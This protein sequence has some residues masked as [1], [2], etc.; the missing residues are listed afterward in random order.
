MYDE[1]DLLRLD[2]MIECSFCSSKK[3]ERISH[4]TTIMSTGDF[5]APDG[6]HEHDLNIISMTYL[7]DNEHKF[8]IQPLNS[9]WCGWKQS[10]NSRGIE[11]Y[12]RLL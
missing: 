8:A 3:V 10:V 6:H 5:D 4:A 11:A 7:C 9:C 2:N 12:I 1:I